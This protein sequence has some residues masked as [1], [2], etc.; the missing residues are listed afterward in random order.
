MAGSS[1]RHGLFV[2]ETTDGFDTTD[3]A[4][5]IEGLDAA[6]GGPVVCTAATRPS[7]GAGQAGTFIY[8]TDTGLVWIWTGS[9]WRRAVARG[10]LKSDAKTASHGP[11]GTV[12]FD[13]VVTA[14]DA[15]VAAGSVKIAVTVSWSSITEAGTGTLGQIMREAASIREWTL[16]PD[17]GSI[18]IFDEPGVTGQVDYFFKIKG[19]GGNSTLNGSA[20]DPTTIDVVEHLKVA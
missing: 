15:I 4:G 20:S 16:D 6:A 3:L 10:W 8:E 7:W 13:T 19:V 2:P 14:A 1:D 11:I 18:T 5:A 9:A 12:S 17:G